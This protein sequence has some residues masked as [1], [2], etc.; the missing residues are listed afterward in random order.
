MYVGMG[1]VDSIEGKLDSRARARS[2]WTFNHNL[3]LKKNVLY[4][5]ELG[6]I[7]S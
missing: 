1:Y 2:V 3:T 7:T 5:T 4:L 6:S